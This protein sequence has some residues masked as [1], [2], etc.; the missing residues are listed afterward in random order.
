MWAGRFQLRH[1]VHDQMQLLFLV[2]SI[3]MPLPAVGIMTV[4]KL[5][6][7]HQFYWSARPCVFRPFSHQRMLSKDTDGVVRAVYSWRL[8]E[9]DRVPAGKKDKGALRD[10]EEAIN[11]KLEVNISV[12]KGKCT[13]IELV[14]K[15]IRQKAGVKKT[16]RLGYQTVLRFLSKDPFG[17]KRIDEVKL[18]DA[19]EWLIKLQQEDK[20]S[21]ST[22]YRRGSPSL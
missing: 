5:F 4:L 11:L 21:Y 16:T 17:K 18:S 14:E 15:Y 13:V 9:T 3:Q 6:L 19:K 10:L 20:K 12:A 8:V 22:I 2:H 1:T 7:I